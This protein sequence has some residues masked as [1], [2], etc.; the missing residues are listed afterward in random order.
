MEGGARAHLARQQRLEP[1]NLS[2]QVGARLGPRSLQRSLLRRERLRLRAQRRRLVLGSGGGELVL[3][4]R[5]RRLQR[6]RQLLQRGLHLRL[7]LRTQ[8]G[9]LAL[10]C[11]GQG[12]LQVGQRLGLGRFGG[13]GGGGHRCHVLR[14]QALHRGA[15]LGQLL[16]VCI[17]DGL[18]AHLELQL[19]GW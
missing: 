16:L 2:L 5:K 18:L 13:G 10:A 8:H 7:Q 15:Q 1:L 14:L 3:L 19:W 6:R 11:G 12:S 9:L 4:L 17:D